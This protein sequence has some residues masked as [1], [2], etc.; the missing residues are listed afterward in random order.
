MIAPMTRSANIP[1]TTPPAM[2][3]ASDF[4]LDDVGVAVG[5]AVINCELV[6]DDVSVD[7]T[8]E[9]EDEAVDVGAT[10]QDVSVPFVMRKMSD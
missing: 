7:A 8:E 2:A 4:L 10:R 5:Q 1:P 6:D 9:D 3:P